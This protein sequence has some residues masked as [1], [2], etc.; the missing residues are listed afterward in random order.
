MNTYQARTGFLSSATRLPTIE[1][2]KKTPY[3]KIDKVDFREKK[4][5]IQ[6]KVSY[7]S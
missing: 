4:R 1:K 7:L 2:E 3:E 5:Y 6:E